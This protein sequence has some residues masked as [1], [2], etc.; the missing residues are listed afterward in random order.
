MQDIRKPYSRSRSN[1]DIQSR[2]EKFETNDYSEEEKDYEEEPVHIPVRTFRTRRNIDQMEMY[3]RRRREGVERERHSDITYRD[4]R[5]RYVRRQNSFGSLGTWAFIFT[6]VILAGGAGLLTYVFDRAT[7]TIIP[8]HQDIDVHKTLLLS[9]EGDGVPFIVASSS[10]SKT[11]S[12]SLSES[13]KVE[14]KASGN[15]VIYNKYDSEP[16]KLIKN[17]RFESSNGK[18]YRINQSVTVPGMKG[19]IPGSVEVTVY[20]DSYG[21]DYNSSPTDFTIPGFKGTPRYTGF[22]ARSNGS[23][24]GGSSGNVSLASLSD[25]NAAKDELAL[26]LAQSIKAELGKVKKE[27][28]S[29]LYSAIAVEYVDNEQDLLQGVTSVYEVTATGYLMLADSAQL[30][31]ALAQDIRKYQGEDV[32]LGYD[33]ALTYTTKDTAKI[34]KDRSIEVLVAG[35]PRII[36]TTPNAAIKEMLAGKKRDEFQPLMRT[37]ESVEGGEISFSPL[38]LSSFPADPDKIAVVESLPKR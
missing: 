35:S 23:I 6:V 18:I 3:P 2:V 15:I 19:D 33:E 12:L 1:R 17:T 28:Y 20:A 26:E 34:A 24:T 4:P 21:A 29:G 22:Y 13:K 10:M 38:W 9:V 14:A 37:V 7:V 8:K 16:Q 30:A 36:W 31:K 32:R 25:I 27:G 5:T 11:K